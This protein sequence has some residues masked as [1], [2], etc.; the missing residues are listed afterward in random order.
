MT[1]YCSVHYDVDFD[2]RKSVKAITIGEVLPIPK[3]GK[4]LET[5]F[6]H[7]HVGDYTCS[8]PS[9]CFTADFNTCTGPGYY[10]LDRVLATGE[11]PVLSNTHSLKKKPVGSFEPHRRAMSKSKFGITKSTLNL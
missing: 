11:V 6:G 2:P 5:M 8:T 1:L 7:C 3:K 4:R 9:E 10:D